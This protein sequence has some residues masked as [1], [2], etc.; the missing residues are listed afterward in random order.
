MRKI[1]FIFPGQGSQ[2]V[3]MG[4]EL[5]DSF[6]RVKKLYQK[7]NEV[8]GVD[9]T[10]LCFKGP[11]EDLLKTENTQPAILLV[12]IAATMALK[13]HGYSPYM[14]AGLSLGE[15]GAS[16]LAEALSLEDA[17]RLVRKRGQFMQQ[18]VPIG[19]GAMAAIIGLPTEK[20]EECCRLAEVEGTVNPANYNCPGQIVVSGHKRA[21]AEACSLAK[22]MGARRTLMLP[23]SA[24]FHS[25]LLEPAG[26]R[27][28]GELEKIT[29]K[30][31]TIPLVSNVHATSEFNPTRI[32]EN[33]VMQVSSPVR[34]E[35][36]VRYMI[37]QG[38]DTFI[39]VGPG[40][41]LNGFLRRISRDIKSY[42][43]EDISS[44]EK[45]LRGLEGEI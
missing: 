39:E 38:I 21:V 40:K 5:Y 33:L 32:L 44:L 24:P 11:E 14:T 1:A 29:I 18:A 7:A 22:Q 9:M 12:S 37:S 23:V 2:Y 10:N 35:E 17:I 20:V 3:G 36:S 34:W 16:V 41:A 6:D 43:V 42:N 19:V 4:Q 25:P 13:E 28:R 15:Y 8:L 27:L 45:T 26:I 31:P 30:R